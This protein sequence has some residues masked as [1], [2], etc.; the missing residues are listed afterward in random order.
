MRCLTNSQH[1]AAR[2]EI[3]LVDFNPDQ[4]FWLHDKVLPN[5]P[6]VIIRSNFMDNPYLPA[7][8]LNNILMKKDK[9][10]FENWWRVYGLGELGK[11]EGLIFPNW[12]Y[13]DFPSGVPYGFGLDFGFNDPDAMVKC[14]VDERSKTMFWDEQIYKSGN[15][16]DDLKRMI[17]QRCSRNDLI[18]ADSADARMIKELSRYY[19]VRATHKGKV[20]WSVPESIKIMQGY[21]HVITESSVNLAKEFNNYLWSDKKAGIP[22]A[23]FDHLI[24]AGRYWFQHSKT[25]GSGKQQWTG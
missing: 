1:E 23:G 15:S 25:A 20:G 24:D 16:S 21:Q 22:M 3:T 7:G 17:G 6:H 18:I 10:G 8:E 9:P 4:E 11:L 2:S 5:F 14:Y 12:Q 13:G 19:N